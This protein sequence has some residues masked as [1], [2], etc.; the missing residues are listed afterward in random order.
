MPQDRERDQP[1][2]FGERDA[3]HTHRGAA[4]EY[5]NIRDREADAL[6]AG[7]GEQH[8]IML[9]ADCTSTI[10]SSS[11]SFIA[12]M[13]ERRTSTKSESLLRRTVPP[14]VANITSS[15]AQDDSS[16]GS[17]MMVVMRSP[18]S[19]GRMLIKA[20]P[21]AFGAAIGSRQTFSLYTCLR[22]EK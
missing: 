1:I 21:R 10:A 12:M 7:S 20:L 15:C 5:A 11:A 22:E 19:S 18:C 8:V 9:G 3:A 6:A 4:R 16:S 17:G 14:V 2:A 13:P